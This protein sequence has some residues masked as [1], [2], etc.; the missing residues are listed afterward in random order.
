ML[1]CLPDHFDREPVQRF[2]QTCIPYPI[3]LIKKYLIKSLDKPL[4]SLDYFDI[5]YVIEVWTNLCSLPD[6]FDREY[7]IKSVGKSMPS[8]QSL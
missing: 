5:E 8:T 1:C 3:I 2:G 4:S 7:L 6:H